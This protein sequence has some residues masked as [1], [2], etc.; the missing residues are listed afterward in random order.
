[1]Q[2]YSKKQDLGQGMK[3]V[4]SIEARL[5]NGG[6]ITE[7]DMSKIDQTLYWELQARQETLHDADPQHNPSSV[8]GLTTTAMNDFMTG[9]GKVSDTF[10]NSNLGISLVS[11]DN[12]AQGNHYIL[13]QNTASGQTTTVYDPDSIKGANG[14]LDQVTHDQ[15]TI[16]TYI[17]A[18]RD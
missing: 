4:K 14:G 10:K 1:M 3:D 17:Q 15:N 7:S 13:H 6:Q 9:E 12:S 16:N 18:D 2:D 5:K 8:D 11:T